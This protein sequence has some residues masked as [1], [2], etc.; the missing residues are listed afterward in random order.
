VIGADRVVLPTTAEARHYL[1]PPLD[2]RLVGDVL[3]G[4][5]GEREGYW[6]VLTPSCDLVQGKAEAVLLVG[7]DD[8]ENAAEARGW[9]TGLPAEPSRAKT[10]TLRALLTNNRRDGQADRY[11]FLPGALT[12]RRGTKGHGPY[13]AGA[14]NVRRRRLD[15]HGHS[16]IHRSGELRW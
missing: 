12:A 6:V 2:E 1:L 10:E 5:A 8:L 3:H 4:R 16:H 14:L 7:A 9:R 13:C 15:R 11:H